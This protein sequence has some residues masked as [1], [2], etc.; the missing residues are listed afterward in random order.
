MARVD[1]LLHLRPKVSIDDDAK[2]GLTQLGE[3]LTM[4]SCAPKA[5]NV[6]NIV[7]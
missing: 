7:I 5:S 6:S 2:G 1:H 3:L 4:I